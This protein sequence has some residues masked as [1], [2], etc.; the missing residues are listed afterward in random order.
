MPKGSEDRFGIG[1]YHQNKYPLYCKLTANSLYWLDQK[2]RAGLF[3]TDIKTDDI[4]VTCEDKTQLKATLFTPSTPAKAAIMVGPATGI[5]RQFYRAFATYLCEQG[6]GVITFDNRGI[7]ESCNVPLKHCNASLVSWGEQDMPAVLSTLKSHFSHC[8]YFLVGHSAGGQLLGLMHNVHDLS[9]FCNFGSS[10]GSLRNMRKGYLIKAHFFM[11]GFIPLSNFLFGCTNSQ[12]VGMGE[13]LPKKV[14]RQWQQWCNGSGYIKTAFGKEVKNHYFDDIRI[15]SKWL[16]ATDD[17]IA[18]IKNVYD[19]ISVFPNMKAEVEQLDPA[20]H[21]VKDI[22]HMK[23]FSRK[24]QHL[25]PKVTEYF[26]SV[27]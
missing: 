6:Y 10:S 25:W 17:D 15:P 19:M 1:I 3:V 5:K 21:N 7:G 12:W 4:F 2:L 24:C 20:E 11:N 27:A 14:A 9:A 18:N 8:H 26:D 16:L 22:G 23:F 13:P